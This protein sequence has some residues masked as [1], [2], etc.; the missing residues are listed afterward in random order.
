MIIDSHVHTHYSHGDSEVCRIVTEAIKKDIDDIGFSEHFHYDFFSDLGLPTVGGREVN[1]TL[2]DNFKLYYNAVIK[3][4][5][6]FKD[7]I[8]IRVGAEVD[9]LESRATQIRAALDEKPFLHDYK[10]KNPDRKFEFDFIMGATHFVGQPLKYFSDY[11]EQGDDWMIDEYFKSIEACIKSGIFDIIAH[12][13]TVKYFID[14]GFGYYRE[15]I[16]IIVDL[17]SKHNVAIDVNTDYMKNPINNKIE[18]ERINPGIEMLTMCKEKNIPMVLG[19]DA[20]TPNK[21]A[22][23][24]DYALAGLKKIGIKE[25]HYF[26]NRKLISYEIT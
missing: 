21:L 19:S 6:D 25:L 16:E 24:F 13:E 5:D 7:K 18:M 23:N 3:A 20:H 22:N 26:K 2:F 14:K 12:P 1:G 11:K 9:F 15:R 10:E 4:M 8:N 17:L